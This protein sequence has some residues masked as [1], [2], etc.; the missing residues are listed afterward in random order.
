MVLVSSTHHAAPADERYLRNMAGTE[1]THTRTAANDRRARS[2]WRST[3]L[4]T[5]KNDILRNHPTLAGRFV[6]QFPEIPF[7]LS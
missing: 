4:G 3:S 5:Q 1:F 7:T 2:V 6:H